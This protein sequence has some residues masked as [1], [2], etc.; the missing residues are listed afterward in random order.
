MAYKLGYTAEKTHELLGY[1]EKLSIATVN[2]K[3]RNCR[4]LHL[5]N[6]TGSLSNVSRARR[7]AW[8]WVNRQ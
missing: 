3:L 5:G 1:G 7:E 8:E 4:F 6:V 2:C